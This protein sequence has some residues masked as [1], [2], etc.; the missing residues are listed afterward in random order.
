MKLSFTYNSF[1]RL[2][3]YNKVDLKHGPFSWMPNI[4]LLRAA[5]YMSYILACTTSI[6]GCTPDPMLMKDFLETQKVRYLL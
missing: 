5:V 1:T 2:S 6:T 4:A 3:H